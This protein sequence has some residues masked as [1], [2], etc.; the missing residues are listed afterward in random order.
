MMN[1]TTYRGPAACA[2]LLAGAMAATGHSGAT[3]I[4]GERMMGM[5]MLS[6]QIKLLAPIA[7]RPKSG[8]V[9]KLITAAE[10]ISMHAGSAMTDLFPEGSL[11]APSEARAEIWQNWG[12]FVA[13]ADR[14]G[15]LGE[16]LEESAKALA[17]EPEPEA[18]EKPSTSIAEVSEWERMDF[19]WLMGLSAA[20]AFIAEPVTTREIGGASD[21]PQV[22]TVRAVYSDV[23]A[24]CAACHSTFRR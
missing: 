16:E 23:S 3:G 6:E 17:L 8:D 18:G 10:M 2:V 20:P 4:V 21:M 9:Q 13:Y 12:E 7:E 1:K 14:L 15:E 24:T 19:A 11:D 5:M 22:R